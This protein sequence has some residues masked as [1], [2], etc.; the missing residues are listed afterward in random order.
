MYELYC[1]KRSRGFRVLWALEEIGADYELITTKPRSDEAKAINPSGKIPF[2]K[3]DDT[4][5]TDSV[6]IMTFLADRHNALTFP[7]GTIERG[8]QDGFTNFAND[9]LDG[10]LWTALRYT[11]GMPEKYLL[12]QIKKPLIGE[13]KHAMQALEA[14]LGDNEYV[15]GETFTIAD[16]LIVHCCSWAR[17]FDFAIGSE[18][19]DAYVDNAM[20]RPAYRRAQKA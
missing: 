18:R 7:A 5:L 20:E 14:R 2:M 17:N 3:V 12:P 4:I 16:I 19:V 8:V 15:M 11:V 9:Q 13:F 6:A 10:T 1:T